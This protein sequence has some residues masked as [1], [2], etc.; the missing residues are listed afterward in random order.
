MKCRIGDEI[1]GKIYEGCPLIGCANHPSK[2]LI[3]GQFLQVL[4][5]TKDT[6]NLQDIETKETLKIDKED[7]QFCRLGWAI[8]YQA[9][10]GRSLKEKTRIHDYSH[11]F[12]TSLHLSLAI[13]RVV[14][15]NLI[16]F[17]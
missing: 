1:V 15:Q 6:V 12:F 5:W 4:D 10:Q 2:N 7:L 14:D 11:R 16:D 3:N 13:S 17:A 8:T 9:S